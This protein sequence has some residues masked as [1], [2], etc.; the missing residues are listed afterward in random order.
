MCLRFYWRFSE[1]VASTIAGYTYEM[2]KEN[3]ISAIIGPACSTAGISG[4]I[5]AYYNTPQFL[6]GTS[7]FTDFTAPSL[8]RLLTNFATNTRIFVMCFDNPANTRRV[9]LAAKDAGFNTTDFV[10]LNVDS[11]M[12][13]YVDEELSSTLYDSNKPPDGRDAEAVGM[14]KYMFHLQFSMRGGL[15]SAFNNFREQM[16]TYMA[17]DPFNCTVECKDYTKGTY[18]SA[19][20]YDA[21]L[22]YFTAFAHA[23]NENLVGNAT[24]ESL[25]RN[26]S[27][28]SSYAKGVFQ[29]LSGQFELDSNMTRNSEFS[30][31]TY[32]QDSP[33]NI[34]TWLYLI[35]RTSGIHPL[36][37][38]ACGYENENCPKSFI[39]EN[40][41]GFIF[42][43]IGCALIVFVVLSFIWYGFKVKRDEE[44]RQDNLWTIHFSTLVKYA[45]YKGSFTEM[46]SKRSIQ[47]SNQSSMSHKLSFKEAEG[48]KF[49]MMVYRNEAIIACKHEVNYQLRK[50]DMRHMRLLRAMDY[51][52]VNKFI[53]FSSDGPFPTSFWK[54]C[55]RGSLEDV[56]TSDKT[57]ITIDAFFTYSI[58][59]DI[60]EGLSYLHRS[61]IVVHGSLKSSSCLVDERWSVKLSNFGLPFIRSHEKKDAHDLLWTAPEILRAEKPNPSKPADI[62]AASI[63]FSEVINQKPA[64][65]NTDLAGGIDEVIYMIKHSTTKITRP[66]FQEALSDLNPA[67]LH[68]VRDMWNENP[69]DRP[70]IETIKMLAKSMNP[71]KASNLMDHVF[72][73]LEDYAAS[74]EEDIQERTKELVEE[75]KKADALLFRMLPKQVAEKLKLG[76]T[77]VPESFDSV[78]IFFS[79][80]VGFTTLASKCSNLQV[81]DLLNNLYTL[82]DEIINAHDIFK[83]ETI[84]DGLLCASGVPNRNGKMHVIEICDMALE[85][86]D[87][88]VNFRIP[89]LP[90]EK[91]LIRI[92][93]HSD[94]CVAGVVGLTAPRYCLFGDSVNTASRMESSSKPSRV[95]LSTEAHTLLSE[96]GGYVTEPRGEIIVKGKGVL[97]TFWLLG[98]EGVY[99]GEPK[100]YENYKKELDRDS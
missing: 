93:V 83:V 76:Q 35:I 21:A 13:Y 41:V 40:T 58:I 62:Y 74:L 43:V 27:L 85:L 2:I 5:A 78:T 87:K 55:S 3:D 8:N 36:N 44:K 16:P 10:F 71:G 61:P 84:G 22:V 57:S 33:D 92:G 70:K 95:Q 80:I 12:D 50:E 77:V 86:I 65:E 48:G 6:W 99:S 39:E 46:Q 23:I 56:F 96:L 52:N 37:E 38:P 54:F 49:S 31:S 72:G 45:D 82:F 26:G 28:I 34:T 59:K 42:I 53:G 15:S 73:M 19:F 14:A 29:G 94:S 97:S 11:D 51:E 68:M 98:K 69:S 7:M 1:C 32:V 91:V 18:Y 47:S 90:K 63:I 30:F 66:I 17:Q 75:Q 81:V 25:A 79:D 60:I 88:L 100:I 64:Y 20:L 24:V 9:M 67:L 4:N 89:H